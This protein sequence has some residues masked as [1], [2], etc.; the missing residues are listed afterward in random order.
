MKKLAILSLL[1]LSLETTFFAQSLRNFKVKNESNAKERTQMLD[2]LR[3]DIKKD[4]KQ[5]VIFV[6]NHFMCSGVYAW[7]EGSVQRK[8]GKPLTFPDDFYDCCHVEALFKKVNGNWTLK[9][10]GAF[11]TDVW[12]NCIGSNYPNIDTRIL[13]VDVR[14]LFFCD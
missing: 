3:N 9:A 14:N 2:L 10:Q 5:D 4:I 8:D 6:V 13:S 7:M 1:F 12:Y 11:S